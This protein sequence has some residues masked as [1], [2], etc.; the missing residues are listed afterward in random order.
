MPMS[1]SGSKYAKELLARSNAGDQRS[2]VELLQDY[3]DHEKAEN[4]LIGMAFT[5]GADFAVGQS[6]N[7][8]G[9][10]KAARVTLAMLACDG[11]VVTWEI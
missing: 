1:M 10:N 8:E 6:V 11:K 5:L 9:L 2:S 7:M 4:G 3:F